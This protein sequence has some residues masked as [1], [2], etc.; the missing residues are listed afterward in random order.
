MTKKKN[1]QSQELNIVGFLWRLAL[2]TILVFSTFNPSG[3]SAYH[4]IVGSIRESHF[5]PLHALT[6]IVL[7][8]GWVIVWVATW[9][10]LETVGVI[11]ASLA[12]AILVWLLV[13]IGVLKPSSVSGYTWVV[14]VCLS[15]M[16][17]IGMC[18]SH[19]WRRL[20]GQYSVED[21]DE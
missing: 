16:F 13:D 7:I 3:Y 2:A 14:L 17:A 8:I 20:T 1:S 9:R 5:G 19:L 15:I 6:L 21:L 10:S 11:L 4:W 12:L 18:W